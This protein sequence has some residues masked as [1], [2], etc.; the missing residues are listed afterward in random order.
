MNSETRATTKSMNLRMKA[1]IVQQN[2]A[3][4]KWHKNDFGNYKYR[5]A[6]DIL[7]AVK[8]LLIDVKALL[9]IT[10]EVVLIQNDDDKPGRFYVRATARLMDIESDEVIEAKGW[11][12]EEE[13]KRGMDAAQVTGSASS[14]ARKYALNGLF[15]IDEGEADPDARGHTDIS[16]A[17]RQALLDKAQKLGAVKQMPEIIKRV[18]GVEN[19]NE[20]TEKQGLDLLENLTKYLGV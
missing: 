9:V 16:N 13:T 19:S 4:P 10:D 7:S 8:V 5:T 15:G 6:E 18:Y 3:V 14:Y 11:A 20:L 17:T 2:L 12:R 1:F